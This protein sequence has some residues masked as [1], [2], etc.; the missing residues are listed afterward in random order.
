MTE[1]VI[2]RK[3]G[4]SLGIVLP[5][6]VVKKEGLKEN[7]K[8]LITIVKEANLKGVFGSLKRKVSGQGFKDMVRKGWKE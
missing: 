5:S 3:W 6:E 2:V 7:E 8:V 4:S 1:E